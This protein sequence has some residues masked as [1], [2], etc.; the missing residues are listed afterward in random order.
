[1]ET[2]DDFL[3]DLKWNDPIVR[4]QR[5]VCQNEVDLLHGEGSWD[6]M[7]VAD[8]ML[9]VRAVQDQI[10][11]KDL[12]QHLQDIANDLHQEEQNQKVLGG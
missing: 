6:S 9:F 11:T 10:D 12:E 3:T 8:Q 7:S 5:L 4:T 2:C 1:M